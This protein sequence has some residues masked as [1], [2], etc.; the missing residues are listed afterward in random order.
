MVLAVLSG[1]TGFVLTREIEWHAVPW[2]SLAMIAF[3]CGAYLLVAA[4][5]REAPTWFTVVLTVWL[6]ICWATAGYDY[7]KNR[8][9]KDD[10][11]MRVGTV[12]TLGRFV[13]P[14]VAAVF[15]GDEDGYPTSLCGLGCDCNDRDAGIHP[16]ARDI[17]GNGVDEDCSGRDLSAGEHA[18]HLESMT[19][20]RTERAAA[21]R[22]QEIQVVAPLLRLTRPGPPNLLLITI[23]TLRADHLGIYGYAKPTSPRID[24]WAQGGVVFEQ[25]RA[26]GPATRFSVAPMLISK[27]IT[28]IDRSNAEWP[29]I[30][31]KEILLAERLTEA[32]YRTAAFHSIRYLR[33]RYNLDQGFHHYSEACMN[34]RGASFKTISSDFITDEVLAYLD[35]PGFRADG[36]F[37]LWAYYG[38]PH[39][40]YRR[41]KGFSTFGPKYRDAYDGEIAFTDHHVGR[42]LDGLAE[43]GLMD[44]LVI[45][46]LSDHGE[47]LDPKEDHGTR[48]HSKNLYDELLR[49]PLIVSGPGI[50]PRRVETAVSLIDLVPTTMDLVGADPDPAYRG[51]SLVPYL[52]G[53]NPPHPPSFFEKHRAIDRLEK[54]MVDWPYKVIMVMPQNKVRIYNLAM[55]PAEQHDLS[56]ALREDKR[57]HLVGTLKHWMHEQLVP[58]KAN[59]RH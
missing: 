41:H 8:E 7:R 42:L 48:F 32:G 33:K 59:Y 40:E 38:D 27:Y 14:A 53:Q 45:V 24:A 51:V 6:A 36:P 5:M 35:E 18:G 19:R 30:A 46:L 44:D 25:A 12:S 13:L 56:D 57:S 15:D 54:G 2:G 50:A 20:M 47:G 34:V 43:R 4:A 23:D 17:P 29:R 3:G 11:I 55:D 37:M 49:V 28:E 58:V 31:D 1:A 10:G 22:G 21:L 39:S 16:A 26:T 9:G 52:R